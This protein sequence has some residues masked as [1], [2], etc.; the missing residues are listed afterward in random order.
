VV[1]QDYAEKVEG[2]I[3]L[4]QIE[5]IDHEPKVMVWGIPVSYKN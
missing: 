3:K 2:N 4:K 5:N 1:G